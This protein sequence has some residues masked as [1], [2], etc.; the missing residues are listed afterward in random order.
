MRS[1]EMP[2]NQTRTRAAVLELI[3]DNLQ[4]FRRSL[5]T[6]QMLALNGE[7]HDSSSPEYLASMA[8][9]SDLILLLDDLE[10]APE[11]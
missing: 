9:Q 5:V 2:A 1:N 7:L 10:H 6:V 8:D 11:A 4:R 3:L